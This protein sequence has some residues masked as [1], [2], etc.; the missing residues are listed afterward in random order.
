MNVYPVTHLCCK[1]CVSQIDSTGVTTFYDSVCGI[2]V[3]QAPINRSFNDWKKETTNHGWPSFRSA[4]VI[5]GNSYVN[6]SSSGEN[7]VYSKC[8]T[9]LGSNLPDES[10]DRF[11]IDLSCISGNEMYRIR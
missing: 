8:G 6:V 11:C 1:L 9:Y 5:A 2:P 7:A 3:F 4:E 10:G